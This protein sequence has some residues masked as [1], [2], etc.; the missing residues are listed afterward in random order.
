[1]IYK[2]GKIMIQV[3][4]NEKDSIAILKPNGALSESDFTSARDIIDPF[5]ENTGNLKGIIIYVKTFPGWDS[6][7]ALITHLKFINSHH[8]KI[9]KVAFV[10]DSMIGDFVELIARH[11]V[12]AQIKSFPFDNFEEAKTWILS[13][14]K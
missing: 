14:K 7:S 2:K 1:M 10:S 12:E 3:H 13:K 8:K 4:L 6:F 9:S 11:F 5:I